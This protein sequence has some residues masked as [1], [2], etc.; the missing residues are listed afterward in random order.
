M[1]MSKIELPSLCVILNYQRVG[2][3]RICRLSLGFCKRSG[4]VSSRQKIDE[5]RLFCFI[6]TVAT[7]DQFGLTKCTGNWRYH[8]TMSL[9]H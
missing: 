8:G 1:G 6:L 3:L 9:F 7:F 4:L 5:A 2:A